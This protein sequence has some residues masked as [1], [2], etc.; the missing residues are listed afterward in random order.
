[1]MRSANGG[2]S[3]GCLLKL[4]LVSY[5]PGLRMQGR[6]VLGR[7]SNRVT[8]PISLSAKQPPFDLHICFTDLDYSAVGTKTKGPSPGP[9]PE[10]SPGLAGTVLIEASVKTRCRSL[11]VVPENRGCSAEVGPGGVSKANAP[12]RRCSWCCFSRACL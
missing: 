2:L 8:L 1:M 9:R 12:S 6:S 5:K 3:P 11:P 4:E 7:I 10:P